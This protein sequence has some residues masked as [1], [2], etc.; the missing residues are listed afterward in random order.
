MRLCKGL[1]L[2]IMALH[3]M[4]V[5]HV[6]DI[7]DDERV[8]FIKEDD[9]RVI[10]EL[11]RDVIARGPEAQEQ[12]WIRAVWAESSVSNDFGEKTATP[13]D[14]LKARRMARELGMIRE[15][16]DLE[17]DALLDERSSEKDEEFTQLLKQA[18]VMNQPLVASR[19][20]REHAFWFYERGEVLKSIELQKR[21]AAFLDQVPNLP[22]I[23]GLRLKI[24]MAM[25]LDTE[26]QPL[27]A[28]QLYEEIAA[29][30]GRRYM[31]SLCI[32]NAHEMGLHY[33]ASQN[34]KDWPTAESWFRKA[35]KEAREFRDGWTVAKGE[36]A[37]AVLYSKLK[38]HAEA[39][40]HGQAAVKEFLPFKNNLWTGD[41]YKKLG[42]VYE[43]A[44]RPNEAVE[45]LQKAQ[46]LIPG[47]YLQDQS[48]IHRLLARAWEALHDDGK[49]LQHL[50]QHLALSDRIKNERETR[51]YSKAMVD[52]GL[53]V[54]EE[55]NRV[56]EAE[57]SMQ[58]QRLRDAEELRFLLM[59]SLILAAV[60]IASLLL[61]AIR[62][63]QLR[64]GEMHMRRI[65]QQIQEGI[66]TFDAELRI[67]T[68]YSQ[69]VENVFGRPLVGQHILRDVLAAGPFT[70]DEI[71]TFEEVL[72]LS[73]SEGPLTWEFNQ[74]L[75]P[76]ELTWNKERILA[77]HWQ[78]I[79]G[80]HGRMSSILLSFRDITHQK[81]L[82]KELALERLRS[83]RITRCLQELIE[84]GPE[85]TARVFQDTR[86]F[87]K[88]CPQWIA[89]GQNAEIFRRLHTL[90]GLARSLGL[91]ELA[92]A[93]HDF[94][95]I[96]M[97]KTPARHDIEAALERFQAG[98]AA[99]TA[100][101][102]Y[103]A[104]P[105]HTVKSLFA[106]LD[107]LLPDLRHRSED[108]GL[109]F[110]GITACDHVSF[111]PPGILN[112]LEPIFVHALNNVIDHGYRGPQSEGQSVGAV[113][114]EVEA[115]EDAAGLH[116]TIRDYGHGIAWTKLRERALRLGLGSLSE[117]EL[118]QLV[119]ED[120][121][122]TTSEITATSGRGVGM[123]AVR[124]L[125]QEDGGVVE[126][127]ANDRG[128]GA[129]LRI[130]WPQ[131]RA[132]SSG[133]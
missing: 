97:K 98:F 48:E 90:K 73:M 95:D 1:I 70:A 121:L 114:I 117:R 77:L 6:R 59:I 131:P 119:F 113:R 109:E 80:S 105:P 15:A 89:E 102:L 25:V 56:L 130:H 129:M 88:S 66:L 46:K 62:S 68:G 91:R 94:E 11:S 33:S 84:L 112:K 44:R 26:G 10:L 93:A 49:A 29:E 13:E 3:L 126:F 99:Y 47:D 51:E 127:Q 78:P 133:F 18:E 52:L 118:A 24:D 54:Q 69:Y 75:L 120:R 5:T 76:W 71:R 115:S 124:S 65:L 83:D 81:E 106:C 35:Q 37:L 16:L 79:Y 85:K 72:S 122:S 101:E 92:Q 22:V 60:A 123:S 2:F 103:G 125:C 61:A 82:M 55:R 53:R 30:C 4:A 38:R 9:P 58:N 86:G 45:A 104:T 8:L 32:T 64:R 40:A 21:S 107:P 19:I 100:V 20:L 7:L 50:K 43:A 132:L 23:E 111:W 67:R 42:A 87:I 57:N 27:R 34:E 31:R 14:R 110:E 36:A 39:M 63:R 108:S 28:R 128:P 17:L 116:L 74:H 12:L 96:F 41:A